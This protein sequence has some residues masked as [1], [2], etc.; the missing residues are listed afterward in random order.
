VP[1]FG[2][3]STAKGAELL[4]RARELAPAFR[5]RAAAAEKAR[6]IPPESIAE[7]REA[8][9][10]RTLQPAVLGGCE[11]PLDEAVLITATVAEGCGSTGWVQGIFSDH[12]ATLGMFDGQAQRDVWGASP[13]SLVSSGF[14]PAGKA[15]RADGGYR[16][17]GRWP[18]SSGCDHADW[19]LVR[20]FVSAPV[21]TEPAE[22]HM[23]LVP[24][25]DYTIIDGWHVMGMSATGSKDFE[26]KGEVFVPGHR[27]LSDARLRNGTG[28]G[29]AFN[30]G[31]L[32]RLPR[33]ATVPFCLAA[34]LIGIAERA[35]QAF[36]EDMR[37]RSSGGRRAAHEGAVHMRVA[38]S[39]AD[40]D[41]ARAL[42]LRDCREAMEIVRRGGTMS[43]EQR[44]R[45]R[46]DIAWVARLCTRAADRLFTAAGARSIFLESEAQR[47]LRDVH[48]AGQHIALNWDVAGTNYGRV[49][50]GLPPG[51]DL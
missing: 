27:A 10:L 38:S 47:L 21:A 19:A 32:Y 8:G 3:A 14:L 48:A 40:V 24:K 31:A 9:L 42:M 20:S 4:S 46:R 34:P 13:D 30:G 41:A 43:I 33:H 49:M 12:C 16:L 50:C 26:L 15:V 44:A 35:L 25:S 29:S 37:A 11:L 36:V 28:P 39:A 5:N 23:F 18:F 51:Q 1:D 22:L 45:N 7:L 2:S 6:C 17:T